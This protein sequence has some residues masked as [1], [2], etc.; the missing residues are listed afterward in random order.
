MSKINEK[1]FLNLFQS[2]NTILL[3]IYLL[4]F[5]ASNQNINSRNLQDNETI[6]N[7]SETKNQENIPSS[8]GVPDI[9]NSVIITLSEKA[10]NNKFELFPNGISKNNFIHKVLL[11][12]ESNEEIKSESGKYFL[13]NVKEDDQILIAFSN[14]IEDATELFKSCNYIKKINFHN[15]NMSEI[16][17]MNKMFIDCEYLTTVIFGNINA[18]KLKD[19]SSLFEN[20]EKLTSI[21][22]NNFFKAFFLENM[23]KMFKNCISLN[24]IDFSKFNT[25]VVNDMSEMFSNC[26]KLETVDFSNMI[27]S[28]TFTM[29]KIFEN[30]DKLK[31]VFM[32]NFYM[33]NMCECDFSEM[34]LGINEVDKIVFSIEKANLPYEF[35]NILYYSDISVVGTQ[36][37]TDFNQYD[38]EYN[39]HYDDEYDNNGMEEGVENMFDNAK[40]NS[41]GK[42]EK[43]SSDKKKKSGMAIFGIII[44]LV[45]SVIVIIYSMIALYRCKRGDGEY[46]IPA[47]FSS[48]L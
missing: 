48:S 25:K 21:E 31:N 28:Q 6:S 19:V 18:P 8:N 7:S 34:F 32:D 26:E 16:K 11:L 47:K 45:L 27:V 39:E 40:N 3:F 20:C 14:I 2:L 9:L 37:G 35:L 38:N 15:L 33:S 44:A 46:A 1:K 41:L 22:F 10:N 24:K 13:S 42:E 4:S 29:E 36:N 5:I 43:K 23:S 30:C 12:K 17:T